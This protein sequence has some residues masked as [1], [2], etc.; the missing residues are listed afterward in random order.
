MISAACHQLEESHGNQ[1]L[2]LV[3]A[4]G[5]ITK[6][7]NNARVARYLSQHHAEIVAELKTISEGSSLEN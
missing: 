3:L 7:L 5:Y 2:N 1:V 4:R 6:L